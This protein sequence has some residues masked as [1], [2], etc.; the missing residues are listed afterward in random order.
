LLEGPATLLGPSGKQKKNGVL[1]KHGP[2]QEKNFGVVRP[3]RKKR[4]EESRDQA[5]ITGNANG[6]RGEKK[7]G[8]IKKATRGQEAKEPKHDKGFSKGEGNKKRGEP[9]NTSELLTTCSKRYSQ[10][11]LA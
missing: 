10:T 9:V 7:L 5:I 11:G 6:S 3:T 4:M 2:T 8:D 1:Y